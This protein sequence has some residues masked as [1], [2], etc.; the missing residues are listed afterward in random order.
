MI[1]AAYSNPLKDFG[2]HT[3]AVCR[4]GTRSN[5]ISNGC[6]F[7]VHKKC[8]EIKG[9]LKPDPELLCSRCFGTA[10]PIDT[11]LIKKLS[12]GEDTLDV[13]ATFCSQ[14]GGC[15]EGITTRI[16]CAWNKFRQLLLNFY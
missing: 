13:I 3:C 12:I 5:S 11:Q 14:G 4:M 7:R 6:H 10:K 15:W 1:C 2:K 9:Q 8:S 16:R